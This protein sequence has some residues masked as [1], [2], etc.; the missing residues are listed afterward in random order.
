MHISEDKHSRQ[1]EQALQRLC[2]GKIF[3]V[4]E[5]KWGDPYAQSGLGKGEETGDGSGQWD[6]V[7]HGEDSL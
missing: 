4:G 2:N 6:L 5:K 3:D 1:R 7:S